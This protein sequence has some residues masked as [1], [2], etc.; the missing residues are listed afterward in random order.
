MPILSS[1]L[2]SKFNGSKVLITGNTGFKGSWLTFWLKELGADVTGISVGPPSDPSHFVSAGLADGMQDL[3]IDIRDSKSLNEA[4]YEAQPDFVFHLAAQALVKK[5]YEDPIATYSTNVMG[6]LN[7]L[8]SLRLLKKRCAAVI[9]TSDKCYDNVE[10]VWGY[11]E[12][13]SLG[14]PDPYS[15]SKGA[16]ELLIRSH[17]KSYF[18]QD[19]SKIRIASA[20]AGNVI[21]GGDW[22]MDRIIPDCV[23]AWSVNKEVQLRH[24]DSTRPWQHVL[25]PL[26]GYLALAIALTRQPDLHGEPFNFGPQAQQNHSVLELVKEM[27]QHWQQ[28]HWQITKQKDTSHHESGL[29]KLNCDKALH[30]LQWH[31]SMRFEDTIRFTAQWY[32]DFYNQPGTIAVTTHTQITEYMEIARQQGLRWAL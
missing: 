2:L 12:A 32:R 27:S 15:A 31:A 29:L 28:V 1:S 13:D 8:E 19:S 23:K 6:T 7:L 3:L 10:W 16:A 20:R 22:A 14:G 17:I 11:R 21:G 4:V 26:S 5:S 9:I 25:E 30:N 24:P 18:P